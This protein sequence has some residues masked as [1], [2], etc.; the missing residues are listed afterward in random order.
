[1]PMSDKRENQ[2]SPIGRDN[3]KKT[4]MQFQAED[5][6]SHRKAKIVLWGEGMCKLF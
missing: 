2:K 5:S 1:M 3:H 4:K 6:S